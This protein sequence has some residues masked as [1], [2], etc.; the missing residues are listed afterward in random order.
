M[1]GFLGGG[2][3]DG[4]WGAE[5][6]EENKHGEEEHRHEVEGI[7]EG[8]GD[9]LAPDGLDS[10]STGSGSVFARLPPENATGNFTKIVQRVPVKMLFDPESIRG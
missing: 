8:H 4:A 1:R 10:F 3:R 6:R 2:G 7:G 9:R 5:E